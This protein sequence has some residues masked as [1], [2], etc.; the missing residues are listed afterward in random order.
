M[1]NIYTL[2]IN[3]PNIEHD[4]TIDFYESIFG[5]KK[6]FE[7]T[8]KKICDICK[9]TS[10]IN[11]TF[12]PE[13][14]NKRNKSCKKCNGAGIIFLSKCPICDNGLVTTTNNLTITIQKRCVNN[15]IYVI[16]KFNKG[17]NGGIDGDLKIKI[18]VTNKT[19]FKI[20]N[21]YDIQYKL[22][23]SIKEAIL[24]KTL[25]VPTIYK[26]NHKISIPKFTQQGDK[27]IINGIGLEKNNNEFG[28]MIIKINILI[29]ESLTQDQINIIK[30]L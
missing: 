3:A 1:D 14:I 6:T 23:I 21:E 4:L 7:V 20:I 15:N 11:S 19:N 25:T 26:K 8:Y 17:I 18:H 16:K 29:P 10:N 27:I 12:C 5:C 24:G 28:N 9:G 2:P 30:Q 22:N 13:C